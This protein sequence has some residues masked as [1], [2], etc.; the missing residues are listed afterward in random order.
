MEG[1]TSLPCCTMPRVALPVSSHAQT[2]SS[3]HAPDAT[4]ALT[5]HDKDTPNS[6]LAATQKSAAS[7]YARATSPSSSSCLEPNFF[8][9]PM[10]TWPFISPLHSS[11]LSHLQAVPFFKQA[12]ERLLVLARTRK[13][14]AK[15]NLARSR[16]VH[17]VSSWTSATV[18]YKAHIHSTT[19]ATSC[20]HLL[21]AF[22]SMEL[23]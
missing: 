17:T 22:G 8:S 9:A 2:F 16:H 10:P 23:G 18:P 20:C 4:W 1:P 5:A 21:F 11:S 3:C 12:N 13:S 6:S 7:T 19:P 15:H 14:K